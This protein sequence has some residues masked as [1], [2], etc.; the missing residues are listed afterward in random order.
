M[1]REARETRDRGALQVLPLGL[2]RRSSIIA[3]RPRS[4]AT[5]LPMGDHCQSFILLVSSHTSNPGTALD[6]N[7]TRWRFDLKDA[8]ELIAAGARGEDLVE[9][10]KLVRMKEYGGWEADEARCADVRAKGMSLRGRVLASRCRMSRSPRTSSPARRRWGLR[11]GC[12]GT[13]RSARCV[14]TRAGGDAADARADA[15]LYH[16]SYPTHCTRLGCTPLYVAT[17]F[18]IA[19]GLIR[20]LEPPP[21][22]CGKGLWGERRLGDLQTVILT[23]CTDFVIMQIQGG[24]T[25]LVVVYLCLVKLWWGTTSS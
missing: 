13:I 5:C 12:P 20:G 11:H 8:G 3:P 25:D 24:Q 22:G 16:T 2:A 1:G 14:H 6:M 23:T 17:N 18:E 19:A 10:G 9:V 21:W 15:C 4:S 7:C